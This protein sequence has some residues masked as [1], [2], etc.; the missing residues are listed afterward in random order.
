AESEDAIGECFLAEHPAALIHFV[1]A[2]VADIAV[3]GWPDPVP[4]VVETLAHQ[5]LHRRWAAPQIVIDAGG[6]GLGTVD[7]ADAGARF[8]A[9]AAGVEDFADVAIVD[10]LDSFAIAQVGAALGADLANA[11]VIRGRLDDLSAFPHLVRAGLFDINILAGLAAPDGH[12][13]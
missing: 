5:R 1:H 7:F 2:L 10:P 11:V 13:C 12:Q 8:V 9:Q 4:I 6:N 3:A